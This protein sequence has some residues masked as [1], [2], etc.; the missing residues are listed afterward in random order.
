MEGATIRW[1]SLADV[2]C[3]GR[4]KDRETVKRKMVSN[5]GEHLSE[6]VS[7]VRSSALVIF[8]RSFCF[9]IFRFGKA[10]SPSPIS[11]LLSVKRGP[12]LVPESDRLR[13]RVKEGFDDIGIK[14][15]PGKV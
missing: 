11:F 6:R 7:I 9:R 8:F 10:V 2:I 14:I 4:I 3:D 5:K 13:N 1:P 15:D 12:S